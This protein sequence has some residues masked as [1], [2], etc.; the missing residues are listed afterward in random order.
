MSEPN[1]ST[2]DQK[3]FAELYGEYHD[4]LIRLVM[5]L[6][7]DREEADDIAQTAFLRFIRL[8]KRKQWKI[9]IKDVQA[10]LARI[11][12]N[13]C[14][15]RWK[16]KGKENAVSYDDN[17]T[18]EAVDRETAQTDD[19]VATMENRICAK[20][21]YRALPKVIMAGLNDYEEQIFLLR[22][23]DGLSIKEV[24]DTVGRSICQVRYDLQ[25]VEARIRYRVRKVIGD[26]KTA[27]DVGL[28]HPGGKELRVLFT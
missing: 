16:A 22:R 4:V 10:Y 25:K 26:G 24:A 27:H 14:N 1:A 3:D 2:F 8:M 5:R 13:L 15:D 11:A 23:V 19:S 9:E 28:K 17:K 18:R 6:T 21:L 12:I 20:E 7:S